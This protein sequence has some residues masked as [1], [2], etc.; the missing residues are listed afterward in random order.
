MCHPSRCIALA[1]PPPFSR[2]VGETNRRAGLTDDPIRD[3]WGRVRRLVAKVL[4]LDRE[5]CEHPGRRW[6]EVGPSPPSTSPFSRSQVDNAQCL[7]SGV[8]R[9]SPGRTSC[10]LCVMTMYELGSGYWRPSLAVPSHTA[11]PRNVSYAGRVIFFTHR[12]RLLQ[13]RPP[14]AHTRP[15]RSSFL[16][17]LVGATAGSSLS[18]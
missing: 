8:L 16:P 9:R 5:A 15:P 14:F 1:L 7:T 2:L 18:N 17:F 3:D 13:V 6:Q 10:K 4:N 12:Q 11:S